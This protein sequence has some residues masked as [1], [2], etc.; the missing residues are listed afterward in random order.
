MG[1]IFSIIILIF[2]IV[3]A[4]RVET[5]INDIKKSLNEMKAKLDSAKEKK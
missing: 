5:G 4:Y 2:I 3:W 1:T